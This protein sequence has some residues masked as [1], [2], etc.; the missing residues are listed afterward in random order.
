M[1]DLDYLISAAD[2]FKDIDNKVGE[3]KWSKNCKIHQKEEIK[4]LEKKQE[5]KELEKFEQ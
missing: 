5:Q 3:K 1:T 4:Q 2:Y